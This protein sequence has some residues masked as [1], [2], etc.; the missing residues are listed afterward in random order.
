MAKEEIK[1]KN[2]NVRERN[3]L[4]LDGVCNIVGFD[5]TLVSLATSEG[6]IIIEGENLKI[7]SLTRELGEIDISGKIISITYSD[8]LFGK[9]RFG[10]LFG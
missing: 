6:K 9:S 5:E 1:H 10:K 8:N 4:S 3:N 2:L 7:E